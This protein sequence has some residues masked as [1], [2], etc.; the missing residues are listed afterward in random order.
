[1]IKDLAALLL[2]YRNV[3]TILA[4]YKSEAEF[5]YSS[6]MYSYFCNK[7]IIQ[8]LHLIASKLHYI[9][10]KSLINNPYVDFLVPLFKVIAPQFKNLHKSN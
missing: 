10:R 2:K 5:I 8:L 7:S 1:M 4:V 9:F 6:I 3:I